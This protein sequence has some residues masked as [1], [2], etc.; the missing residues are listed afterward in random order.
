MMLSIFSSSWSMCQ[1]VAEHHRKCTLLLWGACA[2][3]RVCECKYACVR[4]C[5]CVCVRESMSMCLCVCMSM[6][7]YLWACVSVCV[8]AFGDTHI[9][10]P[11]LTVALFQ[12]LFH[13]IFEAVSHSALNLLLRLDCPAFCFSFCSDYRHAPLCLVFMWVLG[14]WT[15]ISMHVSKHA[16]N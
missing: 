1:S 7:M 3:G 8:P 15:Q 14:A 9:C 5:M 12:L 4:V 2:H 13:L 16:S 10:R 11:E 6:Y